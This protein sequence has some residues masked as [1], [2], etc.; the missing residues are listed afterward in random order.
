[1]IVLQLSHI[2]TLFCF[3]SHEHEKELMTREKE[4]RLRPTTIEE[5]LVLN[6][7][8]TKPRVMP[9]S[10]PGGAESVDESVKPPY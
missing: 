2:F 3:S 6:I 5:T 10:P 7:D 8:A 1:M 9:P 4:H